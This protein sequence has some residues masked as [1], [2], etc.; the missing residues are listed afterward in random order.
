MAGLSALFLQKI[1][2]LD[3]YY[4]LIPIS[5]VGGM[6]ASNK[7]IRITEKLEIFFGL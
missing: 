3:I 2:F 1:T 6:G 7:V 4:L 5:V